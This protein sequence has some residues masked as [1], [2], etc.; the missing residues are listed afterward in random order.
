MLVVLTAI[1]GGCAD[2]HP[3]ADPGPQRSTCTLI[4][5]GDEV[6]ANF[7]GVLAGALD[8]LP[9]TIDACLSGDCVSAIVQLGSPGGGGCLTGKQGTACCTFDPPAPGADCW[10]EVGSDVLLFL[11]VP[12]PSAFQG[13]V[14]TVQ[15]TVHG[16][17]GEVL[18][19]GAQA[20]TLDLFQ[21]NGPSC[22]P[23]C[24]Q[25][26]AEFGPTTP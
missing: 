4:G 13:S 8:A 16:N 14:L 1:L 6:T 26:N 22:A 17:G 11:P 21:P 25:G 18:L 2:P 7:P 3:I 12:T 15:A 5:C 9:L 20:M 10:A 24:F 23:T 19:T